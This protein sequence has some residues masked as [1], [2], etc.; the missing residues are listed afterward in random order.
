MKTLFWSVPCPALWKL[1]MSS[2]TMEI[3]WI[4]LSNLSDARQN[5]SCRRGKTTS[6]G[7][8]SVCPWKV[9]VLA[10]GPTLEWVHELQPCLFHAA[11]PHQCGRT[12]N[13]KISLCHRSPFV[14]PPES[15][16]L[17]KTANT[18][19]SPWAQGVGH[20][21]LWR[22]QRFPPVWNKHLQVLRSP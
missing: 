5:L 9:T 14:L 20:D 8:C 18:S 16:D 17:V 19:R 3:R 13:H 1:V 7:A 2:R 12:T 22:A 4:G 11:V 6:Q 15:K 10:G 21:H